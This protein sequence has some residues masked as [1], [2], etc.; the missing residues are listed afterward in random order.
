MPNTQ[1][2]TSRPVHAGSPA[3]GRRAWRRNVWL[4]AVLLSVWASAAF[5]PAYFARELRGEFL[6][7]PFSFWMA[8]FGAP[9]TFLVIIGLYARLMNR[10]KAQAPRQAAER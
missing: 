5:L 1:P 10:R 3:C 6:G 7:W 2:D 4:I 8:A 9:S